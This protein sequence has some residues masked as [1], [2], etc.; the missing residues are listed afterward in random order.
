[1]EIS[2]IT[3]PPASRSL[4]S[5]LMKTGFRMPVLYRLDRGSNLETRGFP[6]GPSPASRS[7]RRHLMKTGFRN[8]SFGD[9]GSTALVG[10]RTAKPSLETRLPTKAVKPE[11]PKPGFQNPVFM[12]WGLRLLEAGAQPSRERPSLEVRPPSKAV[13]R[14]LGRP[15][16][17]R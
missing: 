2:K 5:H 17:T 7:L 8:P 15:T 11:S 9:S 10:S 4:R 12:R 3:S 14:S 1:M 16:L 13:N 6:T